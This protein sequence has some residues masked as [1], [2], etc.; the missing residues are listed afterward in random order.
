MDEKIQGKYQLQSPKRVL[1]KTIL[2][3]W[4]KEVGI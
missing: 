4:E 1:S 2:Q 3:I